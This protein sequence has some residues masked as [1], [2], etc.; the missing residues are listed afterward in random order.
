MKKTCKSLLVKCRQQKNKH[1]R[2]APRV[3]YRVNPDDPRE[4]ILTDGTILRQAIDGVG[5]FVSIHGQTY[6]LSNWGLRQRRVNLWK[7]NNYG[8]LTRNGNRQGQVYPYV[9]FRKGTYRIHE[10]MALA[11]LHPK[12]DDEAIDHINGDIENWDLINLRVISKAE[13]CRCGGLLKRLRNASI[14]LNEPRLN[15]I[16]IPQPRLL[17]I[18]SSIRPKKYRKRMDKELLRLMVR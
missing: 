10:L 14:R 7:K 17:E 8:K 12:S 2:P 5:L 3:S 16:N 18:F 1:R 6:A 13:N 4:L 9:C 11:W 15:P